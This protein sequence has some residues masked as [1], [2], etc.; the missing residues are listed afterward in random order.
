M[1]ELNGPGVG[2]GGQDRDAQEHRAQDG[3]HD[4]QGGAGVRRLRLAEHAHAVGDSLRTRHGRTAVGEGPGRVEQRDSEQ[5]PAAFV[6]QGQLA[7]CRRDMAEAARS[8]P[9]QAVDDQQ[10]M[11]AMKK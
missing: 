10:A 9:D 7:R 8:R 5:E 2:Q 11:L 4:D 3:A 6:A 1:P